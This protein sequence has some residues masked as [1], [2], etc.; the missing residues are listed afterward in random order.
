MAANA[1]Y[2]V[3]AVAFAGAAV[4]NRQAVKAQKKARSEAYAGQK[5]EAAREMRDQIREQRIRAAQLM[6]RSEATG[7]GESSGEIGALGNLS[8]NLDSNIGMNLGRIQTARNIS[9]F[10]QEA[11]DYSSRAQTYQSIG[12]L[13]GS[14]AGK[15]SN[16]P[17]KDT[18][19]S[20][21]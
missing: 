9:I 18:T 3:A 10:E 8:T 5:A 16:K 6:Q 4:Q 1:A 19:P 21:N 13:A 15:G 2:W 14:F 7:T 11:A 17:P 12:Q 20:G